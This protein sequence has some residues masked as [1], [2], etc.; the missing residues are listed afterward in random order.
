MA[1]KSK[2]KSKLPP[3]TSEDKNII[4]TS[5]NINGRT[6][7]YKREGSGPPLIVLHG[8]IGDEDTFSMCSKNFAP[9]FTIYRIAW[10]GY[11]CSSPMPG[12]TITDLVEVTREFIIKLKLKDVTVLGNCLGG[13]VSM[14]FVRHYSELISRQILIEVY[15]YFPFYFHLLRIPLFNRLLYNFL[16]KSTIS[17]HLLNLFLPLQQK[18][19]AGKPDYTKDGFKKTSTK[20]ALNFIDAIYQYYHKIFRHLRSTYQT[21]VETIYIVGGESFGP[22]Y[23][24]RDVVSFFQNLQIVA[25]PESLHNPITEKP[26]LFS[27]RVLKA[28]GV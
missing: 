7:S 24:T 8:W 16:F 26:E 20:T 28:I 1:L 9:Y 22:V 18:K 11:G 21:D 12:F 3:V 17:F 10:P 6:I 25:I 23:E 19:D 14:E 15:S 2:N 13:N 5:V 4:L 27:K